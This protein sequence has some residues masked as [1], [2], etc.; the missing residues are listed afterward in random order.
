MGRSRLCRLGNKLWVTYHALHLVV[1]VNVSVAS[2]IGIMHEFE[3]SS[4]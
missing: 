4:N 3:Y 2:E 1:L